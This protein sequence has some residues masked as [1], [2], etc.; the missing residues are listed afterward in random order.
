MGFEAYAWAAQRVTGIG[1]LIFLAW[2]LYTLNAIISGPAAYDRVMKSMEA[3]LFKI[4][5]LLLLWVV[6]FHA[7]N[8][9][10]LILLNLIP[11]L[12]HKKLAYTVSIVSLGLVLLSIPIFF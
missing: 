7:L 12:S 5:E 4:G 3:P 11:E 1:L 2:H 10:R 6:L 9:L 8:G